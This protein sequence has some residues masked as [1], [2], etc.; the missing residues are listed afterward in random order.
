[1]NLFLPVNLCNKALIGS[2]LY[3][4]KHTHMPHVVV[5][6]LSYCPQWIMGYILLTLHHV[7]ISHCVCKI[8]KT[9][10][11]HPREAQWHKRSLS[12]LAWIQIIYLTATVPYLNCCMG[13]LLD[14]YTISKFVS[15]IHLLHLYL[16]PSH[17]MYRLF[18]S[19]VFLLNPLDCW[20][21][22]NLNKLDP[23]VQNEK[24]SSISNGTRFSQ[25]KY[26][27]SRWKTVTGS[28]KPKIY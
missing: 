17:T 5:F 28:L 9:W 20:R 16:F 26:H 27:I 1:M 13:Y 10:S 21:I 23:V 22:P 25:P 14:K 8:N 3:T 6:I 11:I 24:K 2:F 4:Q 7:F 19:G 12:C 18:P 15:A